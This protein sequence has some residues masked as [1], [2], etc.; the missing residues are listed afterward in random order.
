MLRGKLKSRSFLD[1]RCF[2]CLLFNYYSSPLYSIRA[3]DVT[4]VEKGPVFQ[5]PVTV[6]QPTTIS[7]A[8]ILPDI[9][10]T[11]VPFKPNTIQRHFILVPDD[12]TWA[13]ERKT[14]KKF[15]F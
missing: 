2:I 9:H 14:L 11:N 5:V 6:I 13:G 8:N 4:C 1:L 12:A 3:Y 10:F 15:V 7:K